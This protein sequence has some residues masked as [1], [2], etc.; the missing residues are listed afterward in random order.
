MKLPAGNT[1]AMPQTILFGAWANDGLFS[2]LEYLPS[3][4]TEEASPLRDGLLHLAEDHLAAGGLQ[5][6]GDGDLDR[7]ADHLA[8][9]IDHH[10]RSVVQVADALVELLAL[11]ENQQ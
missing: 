1:I 10:H 2:H 5:H 8:G 11:F 7:L 6:A 9:V 4:A 3:Y